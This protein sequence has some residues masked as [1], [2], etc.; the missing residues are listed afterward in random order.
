MAVRERN[1]KR[2]GNESLN[3]KGISSKTRGMAKSAQ[4]GR[5]VQKGSAGS[6]SSPPSLERSLGLCQ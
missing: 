3:L 1:V 6:V 2:K 5:M 4:W